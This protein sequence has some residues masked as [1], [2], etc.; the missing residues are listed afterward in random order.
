MKI[1][2]KTWLYAAGNLHFSQEMLGS[3]VYAHCKAWPSQQQVYKINA[4]GISIFF[5]EIR[6]P[7]HTFQPFLVIFKVLSSKLQLLYMYTC[8]Q[9]TTQYH[10]WTTTATVVLWGETGF[11]KSPNCCTLLPRKIRN[12]LKLPCTD[13]CSFG[14]Q[15]LMQHPELNWICG[16]T[17]VHGALQLNHPFSISVTKLL[18]W[19]LEHQT[20]QPT[21]STCT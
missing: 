5:I 13:K 6:T 15:L 7:C 14:I 17:Q 9:C 2:Q 11:V 21:R 8:H 1:Y 19:T 18:P 4:V 10:P 3:T 16:V 12:S 20:I